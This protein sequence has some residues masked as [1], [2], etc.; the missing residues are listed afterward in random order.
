MATNYRRL[1]WYLDRDNDLLLDSR[2]RPLSEFNGTRNDIYAVE[3]QVFS[4][5]QFQVDSDGLIASTI[6]VS[7]SD[8]TNI[9]LGLKTAAQYV[10]DGDFTLAMAGFDTTNPIY[11]LA[12]G[13][14]TMLA[15]FSSSPADYYLEL[16]LRTAAGNPLTAM[17]RPSILHLRRDVI[18]GT[19]TSMPSG[20]TASVYGNASVE[21]SDKSVTVSR[22]GM[23]TTGQVILGMLAPT[24]APTEPTYWVTYAAGAFTIHTSVAPGTGLA[25]NFR[26]T[27]VRLA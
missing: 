11:N 5:G 27:L 7:L 10:A 16:E 26:W 24:G 13:R 3:L 14:A 20:V 15:L 4:G 12:L 6:A 9:V 21:D 19:E 8:Y 2:G 17:V 22:T 18:I 23:T 1:R 25:Y